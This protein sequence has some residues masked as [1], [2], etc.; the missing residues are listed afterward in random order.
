M[1]HHMSTR[2]PHLVGNF[3]KERVLNL[4]GLHF[5][6]REGI[7]TTTL[8]DAISK[9]AGPNKP[10]LLYS[11]TLIFVGKPGTGKSELV[12]ALCRECCHSEETRA[13]A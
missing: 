9:Q 1:I 8:E 3:I 10:P 7:I 4:K 13:M 12:H 11:K 2:G 6:P 5:E